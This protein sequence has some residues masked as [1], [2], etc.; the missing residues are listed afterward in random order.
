[1]GNFPMPGAGLRRHADGMTNNTAG[2]RSTPPVLRTRG[3]CKEYGKGEG[4]VR[5]LRDI[6]LDVGAGQA[7]AIMGPSGCGKSTLL[8]LLGGLDRPSSGE[9]YLQR[10]AHR[11]DAGTVPGPASAARHR[12]RLPGLSADGRAHRRREHRTARAAGRAVT[13]DRPSRPAALLERVRLSERARRL[14]SALSGGQ[15]Q[16]VAVARALANEPLVILADEPTGNLD[17]AATADVLALFAD[18][19]AV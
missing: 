15:R 18:L 19:R 17:S 5:A 6:D 12:L 3:L 13:A 10:P 7:L 9:A 11:P 16:R 8:Q 4:L 1:M 2:L 14:P